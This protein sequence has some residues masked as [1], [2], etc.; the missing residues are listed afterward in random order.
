MTTT[1]LAALVAVLVAVLAGCGSAP[2][3]S[4]T[5]EQAPSP[6]P[7]AGGDPDGRDAPAATPDPPGDAPLAPGLDIVL[8]AVDGDQVV[9]AELAGRH[10]ALWFWA[11][12]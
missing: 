7:A 12:W 1:R 2:E 5:A 10:L 8:P 6:P 3:E 11:P 9:G 4:D